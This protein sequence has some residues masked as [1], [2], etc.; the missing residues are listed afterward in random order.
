MSI[1]LSKIRLIADFLQPKNFRNI[2]EKTEIN[3]YTGEEG[4]NGDDDDKR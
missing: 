4:E 2:L 1:P 3:R